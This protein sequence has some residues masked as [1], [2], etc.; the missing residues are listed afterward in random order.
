MNSA[1]HKGN[2]F[3]PYR[4]ASDTASGSRGCAV[5][6]LAGLWLAVHLSTALVNDS[7]SRQPLKNRTASESAKALNDSV[8]SVPRITESITDS[9]KVSCMACKRCNWSGVIAAKNKQHLRQKK[10]NG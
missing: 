5:G 7:A 2:Y 8:I 3:G 9:L 6:G 10:R 1:R 4:A